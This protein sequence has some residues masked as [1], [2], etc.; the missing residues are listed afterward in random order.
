[1]QNPGNSMKKRAN[2]VAIK[3]T[4]SAI[5]HETSEQP[6]TDQ[7]TQ[8]ASL[9]LLSAL[10][11]LLSGC[12][13]FN[14]S[15]MPSVKGSGNIVSETR[16][17]GQFGRVSVSGSG[18]LSIVQ[19]DQESLTIE[20]DDNLLPLIKSEVAIGVL[21][22]GPEN[23]NL[24]PT[25]TIRY[26]LQLKSLDA[27]HLSGSLEAEAQSIKTD[28]LLFAISGSGKIHVASLEASE[29]NVHVSGSG[30]IELT[31]KVNRQRIEISGSGNYR[32]RDCESQSTAVHIS[33]SGNATIWARLALE[34]HVSGSGDIEYYGSPQ[35]DTHVSG[36][37][38][39][40]SL[41]NK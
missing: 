5:T 6:A 31:G 9:I 15:T 7:I 32:A 41:G 30:D 11:A 29:L 35:V 12:F 10:C 23:V 36:S 28:Q 26:V 33:G 24:R 14:W 22:I 34:A 8:K 17:V 18:H 27:L 40:H 2:V 3:T 38:G 4:T 39:I 21:K 25:K 19:G 1:M 37:G 16:A 20:A 13:N